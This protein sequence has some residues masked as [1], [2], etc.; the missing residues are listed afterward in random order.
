MLLTMLWFEMQQIEALVQ[1]HED[2]TFSKFFGACNQQK[3]ALDRCFR[4]EKSINRKKN[5]EKARAEQER[6]QQKLG[7]AAPGYSPP[8][9]KQTS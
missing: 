4:E 9:A 5:F 3:W 8:L 2:H 7:H 6:L 1:C